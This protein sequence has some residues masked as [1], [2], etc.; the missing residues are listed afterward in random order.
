MPLTPAQ[1]FRILVID[2]EPQIQRALK[3]ILGARQY[4]VQIASNGAEGLQTAAESP[5]DL[6]ILDLSMPGMDGLQVCHELRSQLKI[7][8]LILSVHGE[9]EKKIKALDLGADDYLSK[10]FVAAE[11]LAR[12]RALLRRA[13]GIESVEPILSVGDLEI[14]L[15][16]RRVQRAGQDVRL[17]RTEFEILCFL[18]QKA[19]CVVTSRMILSHVWGD[20]YVEDNQ[21]LRVHIGHL[22][23]KIEHHAAVPQ[24]IITEPGVGYRLAAA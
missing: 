16:R 11:L 3:S 6:V 8:I 24:Y 5:P 19:G 21:T 1:S 9:V 13:S 14:D 23:K 12:V 7:P 17:T 10:P 20:G 22:R 18:A 4:D 15:T 2:D